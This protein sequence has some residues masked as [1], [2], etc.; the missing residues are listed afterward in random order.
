MKDASLC[1]ERVN[2]VL[3]GRMRFERF[4]QRSHFYHFVILYFLDGT[5]SQISGPDTEVGRVM[6]VLEYLEQVLKNATEEGHGIKLV[7]GW[8]KCFFEHPGVYEGSF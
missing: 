5:R 4:L 1:R 6:P 2:H 7:R 8:R 3:Q